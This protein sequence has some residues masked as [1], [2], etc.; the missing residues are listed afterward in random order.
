MSSAPSKE[1]LECY[2]CDYKGRKDNFRLYDHFNKHHP[3]MPERYKTE[4]GQRSL[5]DMFKPLPRKRTCSER[6][7]ESKGE[8]PGRLIPVTYLLFL[9]GLNSPARGGSRGSQEP[10]S[11]PATPG[12]PA[13][14]RAP[15]SPAPCRPAR[16]S[17]APFLPRGPASPPQV[18][19]KL[20][21]PARPK[22]ASPIGQKAPVPA[23]VFSTTGLASL[24]MAQSQKI[25]RLT[26]KLDEHLSRDAS[27]R[28]EIDFCRRIG[29][30][31]PF[32][33]DEVSLKIRCTVCD[34][35][36]WSIPRNER[37]ASFDRIGIFLLGTEIPPPERQRDILSSLKKHLD[38]AT[39]IRSVAIADSGVAS[40][41]RNEALAVARTAYFSVC[42]GQS[43]RSFERPLALQAE[44]GVIFGDKNH[45]RTHFLPTFIRAMV[46]EMKAR[47]VAVF[48]DRQP[49]FGGRSSPIA[50]SC[51]KVTVQ[52][53]TLQAT[54][55][56]VLVRGKIVAY[57]LSAP[58][59]TDKTG[60]GLTELLVDT[61]VCFG[62]D[63]E[64]L[65]SNLVALA[66][67]GEY[68]GL[69]VWSRLR[70]ALACDA[71]QLYHS[72][73]VAHRIELAINDSHKGT[74]DVRS[75]LHPAMP[76]RHGN[77]Y[78]DLRDEAS[79]LG[80][81]FAAP[82]AFSATRWASS[83]ARV[84]RNFVQ[85]FRAICSVDN[86]PQVKKL[87]WLVKF[88][89]CYDVMNIIAGV[90]CTAQAV[91][92]RPWQVITAVHALRDTL[93]IACAEV[94]TLRDVVS[95]LAD[96]RAAH[97]EGLEPRYFSV[98]ALP[99]LRDIDFIGR[100]WQGVD[101]SPISP[102]IFELS[103][104]FCIDW[105]KQLISALKRRILQDTPKWLEA[106]CQ[107]LSGEALLGSRD[108]ICLH[109][110]DY[111]LDSYGL[112]EDL[113]ALRS[114]IDFF[115]VVA[116]F[117]IGFKP[118]LQ[119]Q[120][121]IEALKLQYA[122]LRDRIRANCLP[123][124]PG[125]M[126]DMGAIWADIHTQSRLYGGCEDCIFVIACV[127]LKTHCESVVEAQCSTLNGCDARRHLG[128]AGLA[129]ESLLMWNSLGLSAS[130][131][132]HFLVA[133]LDRM[134]ESFTGFRRK[135]SSKF[136]KKH[137]VHST[138][139]DRTLAIQPHPEL[140]GPRDFHRPRLPGFRN[141]AEAGAASVDESEG[142]DKISKNSDSDLSSD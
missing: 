133:S 49:C 19:P 21:A 100:S 1:T 58:V 35:H 123:L 95:E 105:M 67:D 18:L 71:D 81:R 80:V 70:E 12:A 118:E 4:K 114:P 51:D 99:T 59:V 139:I 16:G 110:D 101:L 140:S 24:L 22:T 82:L 128:H 109:R 37:P 31:G 127:A 61:L 55:G 113:T 6:E 73:C 90:S 111:L 96:P 88:A 104:Q 54:C 72:W 47:M 41:R 66:T 64:Q 86:F 33:L 93:I 131:V 137:V 13:H 124:P 14:S 98:D 52:R 116:E 79:K 10:E 29:A 136:A 45:S 68:H 92:R 83:E 87:D 106:C 119:E 38:V 142:V 23:N 28:R 32:K 63:E 129:D 34:L 50:A 94:E 121:G 135:K 30:I 44:N 75:V 77:A 103:L 97:I 46:A 2:Y 60:E 15:A 132:D 138:V 27:H 117:V 7:S 102:W 48:M 5:K 125:E 112:H 122:E 57:L 40:T 107:C 91:N 20:A 134:P 42:E 53:R 3:G 120:P 39:H 25:D 65:R 36:K 85:N 11:G 74:T 84:Y 26:A 78:E 43:H 69:R 126:V 9:K 130:N 108:E 89:V 76:S 115:G 62:L 17:D 141:A 8:P 56:M